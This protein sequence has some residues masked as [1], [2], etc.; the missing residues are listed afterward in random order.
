MHIGM[1][2]WRRNVGVMFQCP[3]FFT[4]SRD[5]HG[6]EVSNEEPAG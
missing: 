2:A 1:V 5:F 3:L 4:V 6:Q